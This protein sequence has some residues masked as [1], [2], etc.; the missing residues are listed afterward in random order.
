[1]TKKDYVRI[2]AV[3][4]VNRPSIYGTDETEKTTWRVLVRCMAETL[5]TD[6]PR[7]DRARFY[8][9]CGM[10]DELV[11]DARALLAKIEGQNGP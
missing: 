9:A 10:E 3:F 2:A 5:A 6:N 11:N 7:F 1:M 8:K 4:S